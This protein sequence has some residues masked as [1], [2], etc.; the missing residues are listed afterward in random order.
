[1]ATG[2]VLNLARPYPGYASITARQTTARSDYRALAAGLRY[3][4]GRAGTFSVAYTLSRARASATNDRDGI[5]L[6]QDRT[7]LGAEYALARTDRT[8][9][10]TASWVLELPLFRGAS[11]GLV[12][13]ALQGWQLSGIA[14][15][16]S[17]PPVSRLVNGNTNGGRRGIRV[18][19]VGDPFSS[20][21]ASGP[22]YVYWFDPAAYAPPGD[23]RL[24]NSGRAPFRLPGVDQWD[25][26]LA[27]SW[28]L[29]RGVRLQ[30]RADFL[31]AFN[32]T[33]LLPDGIQN[34]CNALAEGTCALGGGDPF[35]RIIS[36]RN[37]REI[38]LGLRLAWN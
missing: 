1:V 10:F 6:P 37:P 20:L 14:T 12:K 9:V 24:G 36:T 5:D 18:D 15:F 25:L 4:T 31:N 22:G 8:H 17:G 27:K 28:S 11:S 32:H 19:A 29:P 16:W 26:T 35:G 3:D 38:Q 7:D 34:V 33:Q 13:A 23:G 30:L 21:P 2:G